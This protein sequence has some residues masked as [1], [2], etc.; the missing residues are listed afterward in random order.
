MKFK[1]IRETYA[2]EDSDKL[3]CDLLEHM[4]YLT[5]I[6]KPTVTRNVSATPKTLQGLGFIHFKNKK[7]RRE[8][9]NKG[10]SILIDW[11]RN[12][13]HE[14]KE[15]NSVSELIE[16]ITENTFSIYNTWSLPLT[17]KSY[18]SQFCQ[19]KGRN[20]KK[21]ETSVLWR[22]YERDQYHSKK[23]KL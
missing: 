1:K 17:P 6:K 21:I 23:T 22:E 13:N 18:A 4:V 14:Y 3:A 2:H 5:K 12:N 19:N 9:L 15:L 20:T 8:A 7:H 10:I 16:Y 11:K